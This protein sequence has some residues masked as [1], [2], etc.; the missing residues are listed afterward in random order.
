M[1]TLVVWAHPRHESFSHAVLDTAVTALVRAGHHVDV[2]DLYAEDYQAA[3]TQAEWTAYSELRAE[4]DATTAA[5]IAL[6]CAAEQ[7]VFIYP[8]WWF[9]LPAILKGWL[10]RTMVP[11]VAFVLDEQGAVRGNL[12]SLRRIIGISTYGSARWYGL[13]IGD[14]GRRT[15]SR[16]LRLSTPNPLRLRVGWLALHRMDTVDEDGRKAVLERVD[17]RLGP[18]R[19]RRAATRLLARFTRRTPLTR[20]NGTPIERIGDA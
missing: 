16:S 3:M 10:E 20:R 8:T 18:H 1:Q 4:P 7:L 13:L 15:I 19:H 17:R 5:H 14:A 2:L 11:G 9:G 6:V 12:G